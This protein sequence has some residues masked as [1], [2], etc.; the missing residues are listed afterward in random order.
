MKSGSISP[1]KRAIWVH[2]CW[3]PLLI[4]I[5]CGLGHDLAAFHARFPT[6]PSRLILQDLPVVINCIQ[7]YDLD[8]DI[9]RT[10]HDFFQPQPVKGA[11]AYYLRTVLH[12][13][14]DPQA[15]QILRGIR[16]AMTSESVLLVNEN[17]L[18]EKDVP[19]YSA[20]LNFSML[21]LFSSLERTEKQ[22]T[23]LLEAAG[24]KL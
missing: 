21:S 7:D 18:P 5:G 4:D 16:E 8:P 23:A 24:Y 11:R 3:S 17:F 2:G 9:E 12:N 22:W 14:P 13:F 1:H 6:L 20:E 15:I 19:L 10:V